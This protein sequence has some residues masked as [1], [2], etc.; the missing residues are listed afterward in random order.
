MCGVT[1]QSE[2]NVLLKWK[3]G[4]DIRVNRLTGESEA[5]E[6]ILNYREGK[7]MPIG[8][9]CILNKREIPS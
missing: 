5:H 6:F 7:S 4:L 3:F 1:L 2:K 9:R 8:P